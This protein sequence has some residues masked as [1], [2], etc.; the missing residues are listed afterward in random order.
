M[1]FYI[2]SMSMYA[3]LGIFVGINAW[4]A[5]GEAFPHPVIFWAL[6]F[7]FAESYWLLR[8]V[9]HKTEMHIP[10]YRHFVAS[11]MLALLCL[12]VAVAAVFDVFLLVTKLVVPLKGVF[13]FLAGH[14]VHTGLSGLAAVLILY[15]IGLL[16]ANNP[17]ATQYF[18]NINK[19][20]AKENIRIVL[21]AD[22]HVSSFTRI[23]WMR[24]FVGYINNLEPDIVVFAG[25]T[26]DGD[27]QPYAD[28][29]AGDIFKEIQSRYGI[30]AV[31]GNH[32]YHGVGIDYAAY[33]L[34]ESRMAVLRDE[35]FYVEPLGLTLIGRDD[36]SSKYFNDKPRA[37]LT[38]LLKD[39]DLEKPVILIDHQPHKPLAEEGK[40][41]VDVQLSGHTHNGQIFPNN[42]IVKLLYTKPWGLWIHHTFHLLV[43]CGYGTWGPPIRLGSY[44][45]IVVADLKS[46]IQ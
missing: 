12:A 18:I 16:I 9:S 36:L 20:L 34:S 15:F 14:P 28:K 44:P 8:L 42:L 30:Y 26:I 4:F 24:D 13:G 39:V 29:K 17:K 38:E 45:E 6:I 41:D 32:E 21:V 31:V 25:D 46:N 23:K 11:S 7:F 37:A 2:A 33:L 1:F 10:S 5:F 40:E 22:V 19:P 27:P 43:T 35:S 3:L